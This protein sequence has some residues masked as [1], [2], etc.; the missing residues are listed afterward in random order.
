MMSE[1]SFL[2]KVREQLRHR[3]SPAALCGLLFFLY[4]VCGS[5]LAITAAVSNDTA[6]GASAEQIANDRFSAALAVFGPGS[7]AFLIT[8]ILAVVLSVQGYAWLDSRR[9]IDFYESQPVS[10]KER[11]FQTYSAGVFLYAAAHFVTLLLGLLLALGMHAMQLSTLVTAMYQAVRLLILFLGIYSFCILA[12]MLCGNIVIA[13]I[14]SVTLLSYEMLFRLVLNGYMSAFFFTAYQN[15]DERYMTPWFSPL[16]YYFAGIQDNISPLLSFLPGRADGA[17]S[18]EAVHQFVRNA[19]G[20]DLKALVLAAAVLL[21]GWFAYTKRKNEAAGTAVVFRPVQI[22]VKLL[23][24]LLA[25]LSIGLVVY[26]IMGQ[27]W[28]TSALVVSIVFLVIGA[29]L[30]SCIMEIIYSFN[31]KALFCHAPEILLSAALS[32]LIFCFFRFDLAG[33]D[34]YLPNVS[35]VESAALYQDYYGSYYDTQGK[36]VSAEDY[37]RNGMQLKDVAAVEKL[38][39]VGQAYARQIRNDYNQSQNGYNMVVQYHMKNGSQVYRKLILPEDTDPELM[40]A[41]FGT[42]EYKKA[43]LQLDGI[44]F[45]D[46]SGLQREIRYS[47]DYDSRQTEADMGMLEQ[48]KDAYEKDLA[49][50]DFT[51]ANRNIAIGTIEL[52]GENADDIPDS[53]EAD[54]EGLHS[55]P[56]TADGRISYTVSLP[57]YP[58]YKNTLEFLRGQN[59]YIA[60]VPDVSEVKEITVVKS[61]SDGVLNVYDKGNTDSTKTFTSPEEIAQILSACVSQDFDGHFHTADQFDTEYSIEVLLWDQSTGGMTDNT[62]VDE[63]GNDMT[64]ADTGNADSSGRSISY[65]FLA[66]QVPDL[67]KQKF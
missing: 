62:I 56:D 19:A 61:P 49:Q 52:P 30:F 64:P 21:L 31:F 11:F 17:L 23:I 16:Y 39:A 66:G 33:F 1:K 46:V 65:R 38:A 26:A 48:L 10:R 51:F 37:F 58:Q 15:F 18:M 20:S 59:L 8:I 27:N 41:V 40:N 60:S 35:A 47:T 24:S 50:Y 6:S 57:V 25:S 43:V 9:E 28:S 44:A 2:T 45:R 5:F 63:D 22:A 4:H 13:L 7:F 32:I 36:Y 55:D 53:M 14:A 34:H 54:G 29:V 42:D 67:V 3:L 12:M